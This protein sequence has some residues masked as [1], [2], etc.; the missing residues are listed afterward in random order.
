MRY[1]MVMS[2]GVIASIVAV[3][4]SLAFDLLIGPPFALVFRGLT[5]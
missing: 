5:K 1:F 4:L 3:P 2:M